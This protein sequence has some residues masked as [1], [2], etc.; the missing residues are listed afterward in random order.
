MFVHGAK[1]NMIMANMRYKIEILKT[2][3]EDV[4]MKLIDKLRWQVEISQIGV[5]QL[6]QMKV[7]LFILQSLEVMTG[8]YLPK[9]T[10]KHFIAI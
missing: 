7:V 6:N 1:E 2:G 8:G 4:K 5:E 10:M 3:V 9:E